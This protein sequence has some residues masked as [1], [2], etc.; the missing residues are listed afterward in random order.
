MQIDG[1]DAGEGRDGMI[2]AALSSY[3]LSLALGDAANKVLFDAHNEAPAT[4]RSNEE[5][6]TA[7][8]RWS[9]SELRAWVEDQLD[10]LDETLSSDRVTPESMALAQSFVSRIEI[11]P[12]EKR[13]TIYIH[14][15]LAD[16]LQETNST[17][18]RNGEPCH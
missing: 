12:H 2:R 13:G 16:V 6:I 8:K 14:A 7:A 17:R 11:D 10:R 1:R 15:D 4:W 9:A 3:L 18:V 5:G